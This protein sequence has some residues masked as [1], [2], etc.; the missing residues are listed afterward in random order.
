[1][2]RH[3]AQHPHLFSFGVVV[4]RIIGIDPGSRYTGYGIIEQDG[5][6]TLH[7]ASGRINAVSG[8]NFA[9]R[10]VIIY[11]GLEKILEEWPVEEAAVETTFTARNVQ[12]T[13]KLGHA[14]GVALLALCHVGLEIHEYAPTLVKKNVTGRGHA[15]KAQIQQMIKMR[16]NLRSK[17]SE[18]AADALAVALCHSQ[19]AGFKERLS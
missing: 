6:D 1:M 14:R 5:Q 4:L 15:S 11:A 9:E 13:I 7:L 16:L 3:L 12:S 17:I 2:S 10:L 19:A 18:D 8:K